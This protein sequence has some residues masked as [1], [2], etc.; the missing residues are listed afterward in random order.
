MYLGKLSVE[1]S[2]LYFLFKYVVLSTIKIMKSTEMFVALLLNSF[3]AVSGSAVRAKQQQIN[4]Q[5][6]LSLNH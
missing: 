6:R 4:K 1:L 3:P 5:L 2:A